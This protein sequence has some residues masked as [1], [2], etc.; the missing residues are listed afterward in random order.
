MSAWKVSYVNKLIKVNKFTF[1]LFL[2]AHRHSIQKHLN[3]KQY[4][5][6]KTLYSPLSLNRSI[7]KNDDCKKWQMV[8]VLSKVLLNNY[9]ATIHSIILAIY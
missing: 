6:N 9:N 4:E 7:D 3:I 2:L 1:L 8:H 5:Q